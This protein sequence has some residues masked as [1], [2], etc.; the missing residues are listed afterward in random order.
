MSLGVIQYILAFPRDFKLNICYVYTN[1]SVSSVE[2]FNIIFASAMKD[3]DGNVTL[4]KCI[5]ADL[6]SSHNFTAVQASNW[7]TTLADHTEFLKFAIENITLAKPCVSFLNIAPRYQ[8]STAIAKNI[9]AW[10]LYGEQMYDQPF[11]KIDNVEWNE[12]IAFRF[13]PSNMFRQ[14]DFAKYSNKI[15]FLYACA[16]LQLSDVERVIAEL[17]K[18]SL[19]DVSATTNG[20]SIPSFALDIALRRNSKSISSVLLLNGCRIS[21]DAL[22]KITRN[23]FPSFATHVISCYL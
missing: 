19:A 2:T 18:K 8:N 3:N 17:T 21:Q 10:L 14:N 5:Q 1:L 23:I 22:S 12:N 11:E 4:P 15:T 20:F 16:Y 13:I 9:V 6:C 7:S